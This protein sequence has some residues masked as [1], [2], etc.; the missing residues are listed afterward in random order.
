M[1]NYKCDN[2]TNNTGCKTK[3][4]GNDNYNVID[5]NDDDIDDMED[6]INDNDDDIDDTED[7]ID[8]N[9]NISDWCEYTSCCFNIIERYINNNMLSFYKYN[10]EQE[11]IMH[12]KELL[13]IQLTPTFNNIS[14]ADLIND[15]IS[16]IINE[17]L[18]TTYSHIFM[19]R[20]YK[21]T[22]C[23]PE[24]S[25]NERRVI[26]KIITH[27]KKKPQPEQRTP[28]WYEFRHG[29]I[30]ASN[31]FKVIGTTCKINEI[32]CEKCN[33]IVIKQEN[34]VVSTTTAFHHGNKYEPISVAYYEFINNTKI[35]DFG[36][37]K[38]DDISYLGAS[39][40]GIC[41]DEKSPLYGRMLE[42][43]N[44]VSRAITGVPKD[45]Y[46]IQMQLQM[47]VCN[48]DF[49]DFLETKFEEYINID[50]FMEDGCF[51][52]T[53]DGKYK[54]I[55]IH[56]I[57]DGVPIYKY[58]PFACTKEEFD[59]WE[60]QAMDEAEAEGLTW[61]QNIY[62]KLEQVSTVL[63]GRNKRWFES[64]KAPLKDIWEII[65][66]ERETGEWS[67]RKPKSKSSAISKQKSGSFDMTNDIPANKCVI[68]IDI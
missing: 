39:P 19:E 41:V 2:K 45:E 62:W 8:D 67:K 27:I 21:D 56:F 42:I 44:P 35:E 24:I 46:W 15:T 49:C 52:Y 10:F 9:E 59:E 29:I 28:E 55:I 48:L 61:M 50:C 43:K 23:K 11:M 17:T 37:L 5:D 60:I 47:E 7:V 57:K 66:K 18:D 22:F 53:Q 31:A 16:E 51:N 1:K 25:R 38:H 65:E 20:V 58:A 64:F 3:N 40:D 33:D 4:K 34:K 32:I 63:V 6:V 13:L 68:D 12:T 14:D 26:K 36:C 54:G 30:T